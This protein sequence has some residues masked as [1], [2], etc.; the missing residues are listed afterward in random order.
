MDQRF[1]IF[2]YIGK[3]RNDFSRITSIHL[4]LCCFLI[5]IPLKTYIGSWESTTERS[6]LIVPCIRRNYIAFQYR[7]NCFLLSILRIEIFIIILQL[8]SCYRVYF[9]CSEILLRS[10][11]RESFYSIFS[12]FFL[13]LLSSGN[14]ISNYFYALMTIVKRPMVLIVL[15][16]FC[17]ESFKFYFYCLYYTSKKGDKVCLPS[18]CRIFHIRMYEIL[19][20]FRDICYQ[21]FQTLY[22]FNTLDGIK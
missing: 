21:S 16:F 14:Y 10:S 11:H 17:K 9:N 1:K 12:S 13:F 7:F 3:L 5:A 20:I 15:M 6:H 22:C 8:R 2:Y 4:S 19:P 18:D